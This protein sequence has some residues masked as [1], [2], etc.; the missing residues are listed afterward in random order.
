MYADE[1]NIH[2]SQCGRCWGHILRKCHTCPHT[3]YR[4][5]FLDSQPGAT[6]TLSK[7]QLQQWCNYVVSLFTKNNTL[8]TKL[9]GLK[10][11][12][13]YYHIGTDELDYISRVLGGGATENWWRDWQ[14]LNVTCAWIYNYTTVLGAI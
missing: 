8:V 12:R 4:E 7:T 2:S 13:F 10:E 6:P 11:W 3:R 14:A 5:E 9:D 1:N